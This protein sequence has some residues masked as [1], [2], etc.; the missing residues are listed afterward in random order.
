M[1]GHYPVYPTVGPANGVVPVPCTYT[2][3]QDNYNPQPVPSAFPQPVYSLPLP[4]YQT[5][6]LMPGAQQPAN[7][8]PQVTPAQTKQ[9]GQPLFISQVKVSRQ[10][11]SGHTIAPGKHHAISKTRD[12]TLD[13]KQKCRKEKLEKLMTED[14]DYC[15]KCERLYRYVH[16]TQVVCRLFL[17]INKA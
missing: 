11:W 16:V 7:N 17:R 4:T 3:R 10:T 6:Y 1:A 5:A 14:K 15:V 13:G 12:A 2:Y 8:Y 9:P